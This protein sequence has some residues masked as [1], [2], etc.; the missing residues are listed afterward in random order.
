[1]FTESTG[2]SFRG[3]VS[4]RLGKEVGTFTAE[5]SLT[6]GNTPALTRTGKNFLLSQIVRTI[7]PLISFCV[8]HIN[9]NLGG[10]YCYEYPIEQGSNPRPL[11]CRD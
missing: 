1:M 8:V 2:P 4:K 9:M 11:P 10:Y 6:G 7:L 5:H 3:D